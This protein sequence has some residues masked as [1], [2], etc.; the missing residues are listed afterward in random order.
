MTSDDL[1]CPSAQPHM[2]G[3]MIHGV[4]DSV[5]GR[6]MHMDRAVAVTDELL[7]AAEPLLPTEVLRF[8]APCQR[9]QCGHF[10]GTHCSLAE[11][12]VQILP[13]VSA[14]LP[15]CSIRAKCRWF[16]ERG[17]AACMRCDAILTD[18]ESRS[19]AIA[20]LA[21]PQAGAEARVAAGQ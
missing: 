7:R 19:V 10:T 15:A 3:A 11:R 6:V 4:V 13:A 16:A 9:E 1:Q 8:A 18:E 12:L 17:R 20:G 2:P 14:A 5:T 21:V